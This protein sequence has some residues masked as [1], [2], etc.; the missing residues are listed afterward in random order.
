MNA[1]FR[2]RPKE[3]RAFDDLDANERAN[4]TLVV[5][6]PS[7]AWVCND[8]DLGSGIDPFIAI[9]RPRSGSHS[10]WVGTYARGEYPAATLYIS[11]WDSF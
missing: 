6:T 7:G 8:G 3:V 9:I 11:E 2:E 4:T 1:T 5:R 10:I